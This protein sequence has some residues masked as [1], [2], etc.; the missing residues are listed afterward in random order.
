MVCSS[1]WLEQRFLD[2]TTEVVKRAIMSPAYMKAAWAQELANMKVCPSRALQ[3]K[4]R[5]L[6][7]PAWHSAARARPLC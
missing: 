6:H 2:A 7:V 5:V 4:A 1:G 3:R